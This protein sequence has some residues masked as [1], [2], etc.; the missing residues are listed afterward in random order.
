MHI[1]IWFVKLAWQVNVVSSQTEL[2]FQTFSTVSLVEHARHEKK[3]F[4]EHN[5]GVG[6]NK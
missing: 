4:C 3:G 1:L 2:N 5:L 6:L